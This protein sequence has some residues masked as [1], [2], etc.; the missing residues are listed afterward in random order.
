MCV[1]ASRGPPSRD[2]PTRPA[3][4]ACRGA[5][6]P[7][8]PGAGANARP[9]SLTPDPP[10]RRRQRRLSLGQL[11]PRR[12]PA[13]LRQLPRGNLPRVVRQR[14]FALRQRQTL[15]QPLRRQ[16]L[17]RQAERRL[18]AAARQPQSAPA[19]ATPATPRPC[20]FGGHPFSDDDYFDVRNAKG[21][22]AQGVHCDYCH[23]IAGVGDGKLGLIARPLQP[24]AAAAGRGAALLRPARRRG[25]RRGL[26]FA[27]CTATAATVPR[28]TRGS[29]SASRS[30]PPIRSGRPVPARRAGKQ[31]QTAT[32]PRP[33]A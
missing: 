3:P 22:A 31:C 8:W 10:A 1:S 33:A 14:P 5:T 7:R 11:G 12:R 24:A 32:W 4:S 26:L 20:R 27:A 19:S 13:R 23:K 2:A 21:V 18:V 9:L 30:T 25:P 29:S 6:A 15:P 28:A 16:R 17:G